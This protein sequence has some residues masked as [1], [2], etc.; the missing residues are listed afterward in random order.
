MNFVIQVFGTGLEITSLMFFS[1]AF[2]GLKFSK[3]KYG[4]ITFILIGTSFTVLITMTSPFHS[5][6]TFICNFSIMFMLFKMIFRIS[7]T[8]S[9]LSISLGICTLLMGEL[10]SILFLGNLIDVITILDSKSIEKLLLAFPHIVLII[11]VG[12]V[13]IR[14]KLSFVPG[15]MVYGETDN[16]SPEK[17]GLKYRILV[18]ST[19][20]LVV[21][22]SL[23]LSSNLFLLK[24]IDS[25]VL[26]VIIS[27][28]T[29][30]V[31]FSQI[32]IKSELY[33]LE[34]KLEQQHEKEINTYFQVIRSQRHDFIY[35]LSTLYGLI[36]QRKVEDTEKYIE[37]L[38]DD[39]RALNEIIPLYHHAVSAMILT[40]K[41]Q[42]EVKNIKMSINANDSLENIPC[43]VTDINRVLGNL[44]TNAIDALAYTNH[45]EK[46]IELSI[47]FENLS[48]E[49]VFTVTNSGQ[50][51]SEIA[52]KLF[53]KQFTTKRNNHEG[54]GLLNTKRLVERYN[55]L[56]Y[57]ELTDNTT[58]FVTRIPL[59]EQN[60]VI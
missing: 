39:V 28:T 26:F 24:S 37:E 54:I 9:F 23:T 8:A 55:G 30:L 22:V 1:I 45:S 6:I 40:F 12:L 7:L 50:M 53:K 14:Y 51:D 2:L 10:L 38:L 18:W 44:V 58:S 49:Y 43:K 57:L 31:F 56:I 4:I 29:Y 17:Y 27:A 3:L 11:L 25:T 46:W 15:R 48:K 16:S 35:H 42:A 20:A 60:K 52:N 5:W 41:Q 36:V 21:I 19:M 59:L 34:K 47:E 13:F 32:I 33:N